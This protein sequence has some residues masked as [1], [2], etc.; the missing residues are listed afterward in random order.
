MNLNQMKRYPTEE[1]VDA[2]VIGTGAGGAPLLAALAS[3]NLSVVALEARRNWT[4][5]DFTADEVAASGIYWLNERL[6][7]GNGPQAFG[8]NNSERTLRRM[9]KTLSMSDGHRS[10]MMTAL[11]DEVQMRSRPMTTI[12]Q[13]FDRTLWFFSKA[14]SAAAT[15]LKSHPQ[16]WL[17]SADQNVADFVCVAGSGTVVTDARQK[18]ILGR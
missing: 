17:S 8:A 11:E 2:V 3:T 14:D 10:V 13:E 1:P 12:E 4:P 9:R 5:E 7:A 16:L 6:S 15:A 18:R